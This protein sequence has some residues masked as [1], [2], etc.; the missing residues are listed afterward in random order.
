MLLKIAKGEIHGGRQGGLR[1]CGIGLFFKRYFGNFNF[2]VR[3]YGITDPCGVRFFILSA[4]GIRYKKILHGT[5]AR[6]I[7]ALLSLQ[8]IYDEIGRASNVQVFYRCTDQLEVLSRFLAL[9]NC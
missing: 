3:Y 2:N 8:L 1:Y 5:A 7:C 6:F 9:F 4:N